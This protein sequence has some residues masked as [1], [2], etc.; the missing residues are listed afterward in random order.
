MDG[1]RAASKVRIA[2]LPSAVLATNPKREG[3]Q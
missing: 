2:T 1:I 3:S